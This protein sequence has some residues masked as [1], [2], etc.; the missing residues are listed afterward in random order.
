M[1]SS[2]VEAELTG[3]MAALEYVSVALQADNPRFNAIHFREVVVGNKEL[4]SRPRK[5]DAGDMLWT[6]EV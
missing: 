5:P 4:Q 1:A 2:N 3:V 6:G